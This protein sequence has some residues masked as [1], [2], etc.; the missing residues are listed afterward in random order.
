MEA[1]KRNVEVK[2]EGMRAQLFEVEVG[3]SGLQGEI[4]DL[5]S[6]LEATEHENVKLRLMHEEL[7]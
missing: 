5:C 4:R 2:L 6:K 1:G 7:L 3:T